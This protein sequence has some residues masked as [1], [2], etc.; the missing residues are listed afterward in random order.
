MRPLKRADTGP[1]RADITSWYAFSPVRS[2][3]SQ[4]GTQSF[5]TAGSFSA[6]QTVG[7]EA[8][9]IRVLDSSMRRFVSRGAR[10]ARLAKTG[11]GERLRQVGQR[12]EIVHRHEIVDVRQEGTNP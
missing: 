12:L 4:P 6:S 9:T 5:S 1:T 3:D 8:G 11:L 10:E 7:G 2:N